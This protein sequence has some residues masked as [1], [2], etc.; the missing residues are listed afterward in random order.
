MLFQIKLHNKK[1]FT[2]IDFESLIEKLTRKFQDWQFKD[3]GGLST[4]K[5]SIHYHI[6]SKNKDEKGVLEITFDP[7]LSLT[8]ILKI[9]KNRYSEWTS[10]ALNEAMQFIETYD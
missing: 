9:A 8:V 3:M 6:S 10:N 2:K 7:S 5:D 1:E 4:I